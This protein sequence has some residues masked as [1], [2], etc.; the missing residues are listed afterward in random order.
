MDDVEKPIQWTQKKKVENFKVKFRTKNCK[1]KKKKLK[2]PNVP[3]FLMY[4]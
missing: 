2:S 4:E 1:K 3:N